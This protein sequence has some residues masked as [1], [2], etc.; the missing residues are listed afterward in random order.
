MHPQILHC[1]IQKQGLFLPLTRF[2]T[3]IPDAAIASLGKYDNC[4]LPIQ[5][6]VL[7]FCSSCIYIAL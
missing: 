2:V 1:W 3:H 5:A 6:Q 4:V 7:D